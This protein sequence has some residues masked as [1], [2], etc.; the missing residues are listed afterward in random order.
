MNFS[1]IFYQVVRLNG[2]TL[3]PNV[4]GLVE[5]H[6]LFTHRV[7]EFGPLCSNRLE[8]IGLTSE[9]DICT[10]ITLMQRMCHNTLLEDETPQNY[11]LEP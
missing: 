4:I 11:E 10:A 3:E 7:S 1:V 2:P 6:P 8:S 9:S 5:I